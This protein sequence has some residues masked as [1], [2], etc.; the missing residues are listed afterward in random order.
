MFSKNKKS[1][2]VNGK[3]KKPI[4]DKD[5]FLSHQAKNLIIA[6]FLFVLAI[7]I[8]L[9]FLGKAKEGGKFIFVFLNFFIG[10]IV[11]FIPL[12]LILIGLLL[13]GLRERKVFISVFVGLSILILALSGLMEVLDVSQERAGGVLGYGLTWPFL[14]FFGDLATMILFLSLVFISFLILWDFMPK[15]PKKDDEELEDFK[16]KNLKKEQKPKHPFLK[17]KLPA[18]DMGMG[19]EKKELSKIPL[20]IKGKKD[21]FAA[22]LNGGYK[23]PPIELL[24]SFKQAPLISD[25]NN[26]SLIIQRTLANFGISVEMGEVNVGPTVTQYTLVPAEGVKITKITTLN[27]D[28]ALALAAHPIRIEAPIPGKS[29]VGIE[30]P[31]KTRAI[32]GLRELISQSKFQE[33][34]S[35]VFA[36]GENVSGVPTFGDLQKMPHLLVAGSTG[37]GKTIFL[38]TL[39]LSLIWRN[40]PQILRLILIDPKRVE[41]PIYN[42][43]P[44]LLT[45]V[46][47][48]AQKAV[49]ILNWLVAEMERR[50]KILS[51]VQARDIQSFNKKISSSAKLKEDYGIMPFFVVIV[52]E[53]AD[54]MAIKGK[55]AEAG[56][57]RLSQLARA[58]GIHLVLATQRPSV[59]VITGL[60]KANFTSRIAFL[61]ASQ[62]DSRTILDTTGAETLLGNGDMLFLSSEIIKPK[63]IQGCFVTQKEVQKVIDFIQKENKSLEEKEEVKETLSAELEQQDAE[64]ISEDYDYED[65]LYEDAKKIVF[66]HKKASASLLQRRLKIGYARAARLLDILENK[67][68]IGPGE[69][70]KPREIYLDQFEQEE[71]NKLSDFDI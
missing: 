15:K 31:N 37:A 58:V 65:N 39:I 17:L 1:K 64:G 33:S 67:G 12:F 35:L 52:D 3:I 60:I 26:T 21:I 16:K 29:L 30:V 59:D 47:C 50:F 43:L 48:N 32:V 19:D 57:I 44:H 10:K 70:A 41:F 62:I 63:R 34:S 66:E 9:S 2:G 51:E 8:S 53:L 22:E 55:E 4:S 38:Q 11:F 27:N 69:G 56:I 71:E 7:L 28:L 68:V 6:V 46:V 36:L 23:I 5:S 45:P 42:S 20:Q 25:T 40:S 14:K 49:Q 24:S 13:I 61:A 18:L 54:L